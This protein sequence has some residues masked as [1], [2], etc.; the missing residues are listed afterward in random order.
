MTLL[1]CELFF[2]LAGHLSQELFT[3]G[4]LFFCDREFRVDGVDRC[5][6]SCEFVGKGGDLGLQ[7][8]DLLVEVGELLVTLLDYL[9]PFQDGPLLLLNS[10]VQ[11]AG[12]VLVIGDGLIQGF[13]FTMMIRLQP[14][15]HRVVV[16]H[17]V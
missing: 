8:N 2:E 1:R 6:S 5:G 15:D 3:K 14:V 11:R 7:G 12:L 10:L 9:I 17:H 16:L 13:S 4:F